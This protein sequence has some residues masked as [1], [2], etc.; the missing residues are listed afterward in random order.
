[1]KTKFTALL[2]VAMAFLTISCSNDDDSKEYY[3]KTIESNYPTS[4][5]DNQSITFEYDSKNRISGYTIS[6]LG[7]TI[8]KTITYNSQNVITKIHSTYTT[9]GLTDEIDM[10][11]TYTDGKLSKTIITPFE[12]SIDPWIINFTYDNNEKKYTGLIESVSDVFTEITIDNSNNLTELFYSGQNTTVARNN[13]N[14]IFKNNK[15]IVPLIVMALF[16]NS[17][18]SLQVFSN[19]EITS[20]SS[21]TT[22]LNSIT[23]RNDNNKI[24]NVRYQSTA[25]TILEIDVIYEER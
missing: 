24:E 21:G 12:P 14:G 18:F 15:N 8:E 9:F 25:T 5:D 19:K 10:D 4:P 3:V 22:T 7:G 17:L 1:M 20:I 11:F 2:L 16:D 6:Q 23:T 13:N